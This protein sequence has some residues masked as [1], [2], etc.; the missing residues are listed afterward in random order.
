M[1]KLFKPYFVMMCNDSY[2]HYLDYRKFILK[3]YL[4][5]MA[6]FKRNET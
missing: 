6:D 4:N 5:V 3:Y 2:L 1:K